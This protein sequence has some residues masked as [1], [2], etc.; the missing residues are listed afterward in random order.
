VSLHVRAGGTYHIESTE[1]TYYVRNHGL[2][3]F[4]TAHIGQ[5]AMYTAPSRSDFFCCDSQRCLLGRE[6]IERDIVAVRGET[7]SDGVAH[8]LARTSHES[9]TLRYRH[10]TWRK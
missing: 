3:L 2:D 6:V 8:A 10:I 9:D 4:L 1:L 5:D 7:E